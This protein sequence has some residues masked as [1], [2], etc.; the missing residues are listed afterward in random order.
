MRKLFYITI[1]F[2][3]NIFSINAQKVT[4]IITDSNGVRLAGVEIKLYSFVKSV[5][6][7]S[8]SDGSFTLDLLTSVENN[9]LPEGYSISNNYPNPFNPKTR[10]DFTLP[11]AA[12]IKAEIFNVTGQRVRDA[13]ETTL[14]VGNNHLEI[15]L[16]GLPNGVYF[17][18]I[19]IDGNYT[20]TKKLML[21]YN[22][23]H[24][25]TSVNTSIL[26]VGKITKDVLIDSI[27]ISADFIERT[28]IIPP[29]YSTGNSLD[30][31]KINVKKKPDPPYISCPGTPTITYEGKLYHTVQIGTQCWLKENLDVGIMIN[32]TEEQTNNNK[33]EKYC[34]DNDSAN[35]TAYGGLYKWDEAMQ[36][37]NTEKTKGICPQ[38]WHIPSSTELY[39]SL[40]K[41][42]QGNGNE[43]K[44]TGQ[45]LNGGRGT[46]ESGFS[47]LF[48]SGRFFYTQKFSEI[49]SVSC[50]WSSTEAHI[51]N[52]YVMYMSYYFNDAYLSNYNKLDGYSIRCLKDN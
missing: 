45:G 42:V 15:E 16:S 12:N 17:A 2:I 23:Q 24:L 41:A 25:N 28:R 38:G 22:S 9:K 27:I 13:I 52:G 36:Y 33:I 10:I 32:G 3:F 31:G 44:S 21:L 50:F 39:D 48:V 7:T 43:L 34:Y 46:N 26:K 18:R 6:T 14:S 30:L 49:G 47:A 5:N 37:V 11:K 35:C 40:R 1:L 20:V 19:I 8:N 51:F 4:G 29:I